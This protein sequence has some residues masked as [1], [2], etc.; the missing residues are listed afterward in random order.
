MAAFFQTPWHFCPWD[1]ALAAQLQW[2]NWSKLLRQHAIQE[3]VYLIGAVQ[4]VAVPH[5]VQQESI[6][7]RWGETGKFATRNCY[8]NCSMGSKR[9]KANITDRRP[10]DEQVKA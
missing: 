6:P 2:A 10:S 3:K 9:S 1:F 7:S 5:L 4:K 8:S